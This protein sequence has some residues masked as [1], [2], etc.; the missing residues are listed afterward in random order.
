MPPPPPPPRVMALK[1]GFDF[2]DHRWSHMSVEIHQL[3][4]EGV[5]LKP[6]FNRGVPSL[7][8]KAMLPYQTS[9]FDRCWPLPGLAVTLEGSRQECSGPQ[10]AQKETPTAESLFSERKINVSESITGILVCVWVF[11]RPLFFLPFHVGSSYVKWAQ[12]DPWK[13]LVNV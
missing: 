13:N 12:T 1:R 11:F 7:L 5:S 4:Q 9:T 6:E 3:R 8:F 2:W 10:W